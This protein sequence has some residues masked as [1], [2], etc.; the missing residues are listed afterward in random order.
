MDE[1]VESI[2]LAKFWDT[3][4]NIGNQY[5]ED[6][7]SDNNILVS[8]LMP[9]NITELIADEVANSG[10]EEFVK[11]VNDVDENNISEKITDYI[12]SNYDQSYF[13][14]KFERLINFDAIRET[15][16]ERLLLILEN[17]EQF[18]NVSSSYWLS[19]ISK[20][21][22]LGELTKMATEDGVYSFV[23]KYAAD[24]AEVGE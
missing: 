12:K 18:A 19:A 4:S 13:N 22:S 11:V 8:D 5:L 10:F 1:T 15:V 6:Y 3:I 24:Y 7:L 16:S 2:G 14:V 20:V 23:E 17:T 9:K 21:G